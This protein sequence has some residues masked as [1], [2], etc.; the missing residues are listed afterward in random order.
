CLLA[1]GALS[2]A[3]N[4]LKEAGWEGA[5]VWIERAGI[6][7][8]DEIFVFCL[9][10]L[11]VI[12]RLCFHQLL[13]KGGDL[14]TGIRHHRRVVAAAI[15]TRHGEEDDDCCPDVIFCD[16]GCRSPA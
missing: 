12:G 13:G 1:T 4:L 9:S 14:Y 16:H 11:V 15:P 5:P 6:L 3:P 2:Y 10:R 8:V 7:V